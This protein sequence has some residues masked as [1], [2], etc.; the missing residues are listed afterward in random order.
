MYQTKFGNFYFFRF[1]FV[2]LIVVISKTMSSRKEYDRIQHSLRR[3]IQVYGVHIGAPEALINKVW[4][5]VLARGTIDE[6][7]HE[8]RSKLP[9]LEVRALYMRERRTSGP[10]VRMGAV[11]VIEHAAP[12]PQAQAAEEE[13]EEH[14]PLTLRRKAPV[15]VAQNNEE[16]PRFEDSP[17]VEDPQLPLRAP[18]RQFVKVIGLSAELKSVTQDLDKLRAELLQVLCEQRDN[19]NAKIESLM[20]LP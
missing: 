1:E 15:A 6:L 19:L 7:I 4:Q 3:Q 20:A 12:A 16:R 5:K 2:K 17:Q 18:E 10:A 14:V 8:K 11:R 9:H 13:E